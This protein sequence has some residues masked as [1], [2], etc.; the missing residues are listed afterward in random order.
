MIRILAPIYSTAWRAAVALL[1]VE[2]AIVSSLRYFTGSEPPPP[3][4]LANAYADPFL[5][6]HVVGGVIALLVAPL[7]FLRV[8]RTRWPAFHRATGR[9]YVVAC[10]VGAP[11]GFMLALGTT[12]GPVASVGFAIPALLWPVFTWIAFR[13][14]IERRFAAH[15]EWMLRSY[16][17]T[18]TA[19]TLRLMLPASAFMGF[20]FAAAYPIIAWLGWLTNLAL[21]EYLIRRDRGGTTRAAIPRPVA[22]TA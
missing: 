2:I 17:I 13:A 16:A 1:T 22:S 18:A 12:S 21:F 8:V 14:A 9:L 20:E 10:A 4:I 19:I 5:I 7:Q 15:R 3:P 11:A 6:L